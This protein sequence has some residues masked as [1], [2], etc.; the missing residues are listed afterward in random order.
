MTAGPPHTP[1]AELVTATNFSFLR[2]ASQPEDLVARA[3]LMGHA[4]L[5]IADLNSVAG[6]VRA[7]G[8]LEDLRRDGLPA[9]QKVRDGSG[10]GEHV[11]VEP[12]GA[13]DWAAI[14]A[15]AQ[16]LARSFKL[17]SGARLA[18]DDGTPDIVAYPATRDGWERLCRLLT[19]GKR[20]AE[21]GDCH[22]RLGDLIADAAGLLLIAVPPRRLDGFADTVA[23]LAA[24]SPPCRPCRGTRARPSSPPTTCSTTPRSSAPCRTC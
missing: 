8:A 12:P 23:R 18:F 2:G 9:P 24:A 20:R 14:S 22:I 5:G 15:E 16:R 11:W 4:G 19:L 17:V 3:V 10:P 7:Y 13:E 21:K 1:Y 6:V